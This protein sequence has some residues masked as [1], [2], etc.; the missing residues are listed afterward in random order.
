VIDLKVSSSQT[1]RSQQRNVNISKA[2]GFVL[3]R[4]TITMFYMSISVCIVLGGCLFTA[5]WSS[6]IV[7]GQTGNDSAMQGVG[8]A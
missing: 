1:F 4:H 7:E 6:G 3:L 2:A 8:K 5:L